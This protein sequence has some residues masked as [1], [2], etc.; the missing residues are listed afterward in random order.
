MLFFRLAIAL[1]EAD[2]SFA[3]ASRVITSVKVFGVV[4][5]FSLASNF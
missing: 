1:S 3:L 2:F 4:S 5:A